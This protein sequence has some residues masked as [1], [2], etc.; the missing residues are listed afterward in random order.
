MKKLI[1]ITAL[2]FYITFL[3]YYRFSAF[4]VIAYV[5]MIVQTHITSFMSDYLDK[6][7]VNQVILLLRSN[8]DYLVSPCMGVERRHVTHLV[9]I[10]SHKHIMLHYTTIIFLYTAT[11][12]CKI[13]YLYLLY[14]HITYHI[15]FKQ[16][17]ILYL[18]YV[19][20]TTSI[21]I[22]LY[23]PSI[24]KRNHRENTAFKNG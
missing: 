20:L 13:I 3:A 4:I 21:I 19:N 9:P 8:C 10:L 15:L 14:L 1:D 6:I 7:F 12:L 23:P 11:I 2:L 17:N 24:Y 16:N 5:K 22:Y 18:A